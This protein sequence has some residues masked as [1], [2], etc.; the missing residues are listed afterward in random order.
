MI[1]NEV[2]ILLTVKEIIELLKENTIFGC[3]PEKDLLG[4]VSDHA[5]IV[6]FAAG[7]IIFSRLNFR[8]SIG[9]VLSGKANVIKGKLLLSTHTK[10]DIFGAV[11]VFGADSYYANEIVARTDCEI[12]FI[13][14]DE[15]I[16]LTEVCPGFSERYITYLSERIY[17][18]NRRLDSLTAGSSEDKLLSF[19]EANA[20]DGCYS[21]ANYCDL[22]ASLDTG[23]ASLYR[24]LDNLC[25]KGIITRQGK[26]IF[27]RELIP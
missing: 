1:Q 5:E 8:R 24:A 21:V 27:L 16:R 2:G 10:G 17:F 7:E 12:I 15:I 13:G 3:V 25:E 22:A 11:T 18:L 6:R 23:R 19:L 9:M 26:K 20:S 14:K 4:T